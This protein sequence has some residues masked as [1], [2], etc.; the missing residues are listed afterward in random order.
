[1]LRPCVSMIHVAIKWTHAFNQDRFLVQLSL[2]KMSGHTLRWFCQP[3]LER[4]SSWPFSRWWQSHHHPIDDCQRS[5]E[6]TCHHSCPF[7]LQMAECGLWQAVGM[8]VSASNTR[9]VTVTTSRNSSSIFPVC[10]RAFSRDSGFVLAVLGFLLP[11]CA[12]CGLPIL[13]WGRVKGWDG[14]AGYVSAPLL[15]MSAKKDVASSSAAGQ[16]GK[17]ASGEVHAEKSLD[18]LDVREFRE[19]FCIPNG[20]SVQLV[21]GEVVCIEKSANNA[22]Y[23]TKE[24]FNDGLCP[25]A[26]GVQ[27]FEYAVQPGPFTAGG[28]SQGACISPGCLGWATGASG[29]TVFPQPFAGASGYGQEGS[30][31]RVDGKSAYFTNILP[32]K[33]PKKVVPGEHFVLKDLP[34]YMEVRKADAQARKALFNEREKRRQEGTLRRAPGDERSAPLPPADAPSGK[35]EEGSHKG[36]SKKISSSHKESSNKI[37]SSHKGNSNEISSSLR[38]ALCF[39]R[40]L[41][42]PGSPR[43]DADAAGASCPDPLLPTAPLMEEMGA[44]RQGLPPCEPSSLALVPVKGAVAGRSRPARDLKSSISG[45]LQDQENPTDPTLVPDEGSPEEI[46]PAV[47][48]GGQSPRAESHHSTSSGG[49]PVDDAAYT[50]ASPSS[51]AELG[52]MLKQIPPDSDVVVPSTKMFEAAEMLVSGIRGMVQQRDLFSDLLRISDHMKRQRD[53]RKLQKLAYTRQRMRRPTQKEELEAVFAAQMEELETEYQKQVDE[54][55]LF[56]YRCCMKKH[57]IKRDIP[58][59]PPSEEEKLRRKPSQ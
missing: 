20:V 6:M 9:V 59:I 40:F 18:K 56:G 44:E 8:M 19:R 5:W 4:L 2:Q 52:D 31:S 47:N 37:S 27:H 24:Q 45:R 14:D 15:K 32:R 11:P 13:L 23:F 21:D 39:K 3:C 55:Y 26:D 12:F 53:G 34:F 48:D 1:M 22:I 17:D 16:S 38:L 46:Q 29:E 54:M 25:G 35:E 7:A 49:S 30:R 33:L 50:S 57:G 28:R 43:P 36:N 51:Y 42:K 58:S 41:D 10:A